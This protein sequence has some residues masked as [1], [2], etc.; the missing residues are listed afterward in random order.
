MDHC[1]PWSGENSWKSVW[2]VRCVGDTWKLEALL[3]PFI[4]LWQETPVSYILHL[5]S[6]WFAK[7]NYPLCRSPPPGSISVG[8]PVTTA[9]N[10]PAHTVSCWAVGAA[11]PGEGPHLCF[12]C[13]DGMRQRGGWLQRLRGGQLGCGVWGEV[14]LCYS[15]PTGSKCLSLIKSW[16]KNKVRNRTANN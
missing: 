5:T 10:S 16:I 12:W 7:T 15:K 8:T 9:V 13:Q 2:A 6:P 1:S 11:G 14:Q 3:K 4:Y